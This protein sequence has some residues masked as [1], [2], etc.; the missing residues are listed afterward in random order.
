MSH[1][2]PRRTVLAAGATAMG[3]AV[4]GCSGGSD[5]DSTP[6]PDEGTDSYGIHVFSEADE[7]QEVHV[8][9]TPTWED[10]TLF[11]E[12]VEVDPGED[13]TWNGVIT[14]EREHAIVARIRDGETRH[15]RGNAFVTPGD[16][17]APDD[18]NVQVRIST[19]QAT[20]ETVTAV[21]VY[22]ES[23]REDD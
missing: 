23:E 2:L 5:D 22:F 8:R 16:D 19:L 12:T 11:E 3:T 9:V 4:A 18:A 10:Q 7:T 15:E 1:K 17:G 6:D 20:D 21:S 14:E 13:R